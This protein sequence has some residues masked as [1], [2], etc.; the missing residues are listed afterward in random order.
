MLLIR[1]CLL[2]L[3]AVRINRSISFLFLTN[4]ERLFYFIAVYYHISAGM[5]ISISLVPHILNVVLP[6]NE[7]RPIIMPY[8]AYYFVDA[9]KYFF[10]IYFHGLIS[11]QVAIIGLIAH[12]CILLVYLQH[13][14]SIF[15]VAG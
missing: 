1:D 8:E 6:L 11:L 7:S 10:Y 3:Y 15:A 9:E 4:H 5:F 2:Y 12:D 13:V 14:C